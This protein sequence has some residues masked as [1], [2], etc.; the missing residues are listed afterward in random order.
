[1]FFDPI[2]L[3]NAITDNGWVQWLIIIFCA[4][5]MFY[6]FGV[7]GFRVDRATHQCIG[8]DIPPQV[9][10][11]QTEGYCRC[12]HRQTDITD[13]ERRSAFC[14]DS[15]EPLRHQL[16]SPPKDPQLHK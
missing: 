2:R 3:A 14:L 5:M 6:F 10:L 4:L 1:M 16:A 7:G 12:M 8:I 9:N 15:I 13:P 11:I